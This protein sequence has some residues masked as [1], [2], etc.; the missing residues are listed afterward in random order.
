MN[1]HTA[2]TYKTVRH[3]TNTHLLQSEVLS[4]D[5]VEHHALGSL[6]GEVQQRGGDRS[7]GGLLRSGSARTSVVG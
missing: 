1:E 6:N 3:N 7:G 4:P 2:N 5:D